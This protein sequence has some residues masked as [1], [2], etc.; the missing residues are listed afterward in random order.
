MD[1]L[2]PSV[3][4][5]LQECAILLDV[6]GTIVDLAPTPREIWIPP[7]L[8]NVL[9]RLVERTGGAVALVSGRLISDL[10]MIFAPLLLTAVGGHGAE[11]RLV[12]EDGHHGDAK[13]APLDAELKRLLSHPADTPF[14]VQP[15]L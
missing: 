12:G 8:R 9:S 1:I 5:N 11:F 2:A 7:S 14:F 13:P 3:V 6:D 4:P 10:D 15:Q